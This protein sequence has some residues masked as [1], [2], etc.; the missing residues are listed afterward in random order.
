MLPFL[1]L[2]LSRLTFTSSITSVR[3]CFQRFFAKLD[4]SIFATISPTGSSPSPHPAK[5]CTVTPPTL[6]AA[7]PVVPVTNVVSFRPAALS[8]AT[9]A[10]SRKLLPDPAAPVKNT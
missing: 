5:L 2:S 3:H 1:S 7:I 4:R 9:M 8:A 6:H 10:R